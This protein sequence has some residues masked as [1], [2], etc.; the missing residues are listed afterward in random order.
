MTIQNA[1]LGYYGYLDSP[2]GQNLP[3]GKGKTPD[4][5]R[6]QLM[7]EAEIKSQPEWARQLEEDIG[8]VVGL[9]I[10]STVTFGGADVAIAGA[11]AEEATAEAAADVTAEVTAEAAADGAIVDGGGEAVTEDILTDSFVNEVNAAGVLGQTLSRTNS[12][13]GKP[14]NIRV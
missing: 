9:V 11:V 5:A 4:G 13:C 7:T 3:D 12:W 8:A 10:I 1:G 14:A 2:A 6:F